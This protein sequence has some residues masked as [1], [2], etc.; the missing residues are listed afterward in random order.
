MIDF[1]AQIPREADAATGLF[2]GPRLADSGPVARPKR[3][4]LAG[5]YCRLE[6]LDPARHGNHLYAAAT[7]PDAVARHMYLSVEAPTSRAMFDTWI[8][9][10][11]ARDDALY[12]AVVDTATGRVEGRQ[13]LMRIDPPNRSIEIGDIYWGPAI[14]STRI[15]T[16]ANFLFAR[17]AFDQ[18]GYCRFEWK[19]NALN[20]ASR[21]AALRFGFIYEGHFR[22]SAIVKGR[23]RDTTWYSII[24]EEWPARRAAYEAWLAPSNFDADGRQL[25]PLAAR[26]DQT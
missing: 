10:Q 6:P 17:Y 19:C 1:D 14:A 3:I 15:S 13:A 7:A 20:A 4:V 2:T 18:L 11:A 12:F 8:A 22:R 24:A 21:R 5:R 9:A 16:E 25:T 26:A 23:S